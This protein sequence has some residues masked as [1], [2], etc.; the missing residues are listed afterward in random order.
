[1]VL[2]DPVVEKLAGTDTN[3]LRHVSVHLQFTNSPMRSGIGVKRDDARRS[4]V[5]H[6]F[7]EERFRRGN[8]ASFAEPEIHCS[9][10]LV[11]CPIQVRPAAIHLYIGLVTT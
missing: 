5:L 6:G 3:S 7:P 9:T 11:D 2:L 4:I 10:L 1:M 8:V